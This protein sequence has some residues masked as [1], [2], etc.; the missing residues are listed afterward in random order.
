MP[1]SRRT[2]LKQVLFVSAGIALLPSCLHTAPASLKLKNLDVNG[3]DEKMLEELAATI[4]PTTKTPG[5]REVKAQQFA[6]TMMDDCFNKEAQQKWTIGMKE[7]EA[8]CKKKN[9]HSF[10]KSTP[11]ERESLLL[12]L[13][14]EDASKVPA[15]Y[16]YQV[17]RRL[18]VQAYTNSEYYLTKVEEYEL[19][20]ARFHGSIP[21]KDLTKK[22]L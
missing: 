10:V 4:I 8:L 13:E 5:A 17:T 1:V 22:T 14:K 7:F 11:A 12:S 9:G 6:L 18:T 16:F 19:V 15:A 3:D 21:V 2:A 20:P